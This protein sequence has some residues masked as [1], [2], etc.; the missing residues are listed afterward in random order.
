M[1]ND[2]VKVGERSI[3]R[4]KLVPSPLIKQRQ[5]ILDAKEMTHM[6]DGWL[7]LLACV[8][9][10]PVIDVDPGFLNLCLLD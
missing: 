4:G 10:K 2:Q 1:Y 3:V 7:F 9:H 6:G 5:T 8:P